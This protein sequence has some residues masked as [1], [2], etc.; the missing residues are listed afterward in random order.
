MNNFLGMAY[1]NNKIQICMF[2]TFIEIKELSN[3]IPINMADSH[4]YMN[5]YIIH[6]YLLYVVDTHDNINSYKHYVVS[7]CELNNNITY[8]LHKIL[9]PF[10]D[11]CEI[12]SQ[13]LQY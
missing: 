4:I 11:T 7:I 3:M 10:D 5:D 1:I 12:S 9:I 8:N 2:P 6:T 13:D